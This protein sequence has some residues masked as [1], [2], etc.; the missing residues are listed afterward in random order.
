MPKTF[1]THLAPG[2]TSSFVQLRVFFIAF[3]VIFI[4]RKR[5]ALCMSFITYCFFWVIKLWISQKLIQT[6]KKDKLL[7][8]CRARFYFIIFKNVMSLQIL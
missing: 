6:D 3:F 2:L 8:Y 5:E 4:I 1:L 7:G